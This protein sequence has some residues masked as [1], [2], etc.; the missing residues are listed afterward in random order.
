M[1]ETDEMQN[2]LLDSA[3]HF[4]DG[5]SSQDALQMPGSSTGAF[6]DNGD[7]G[8][9]DSGS[10]LLKPSRKKVNALRSARLCGR[11]SKST[12]ASKTQGGSMKFEGR[13]KLPMPKID[14]KALFDYHFR[15]KQHRN[16][17]RW[18]LSVKA[19]KRRSPEP[20]IKRSWPR[21][22]KDERERRCRERGRQFPFVEKLYG[23]KH[24]PL[25]MVC[26]YEQAALKGYFKY[27]EM[28]K[29]EHHLKKSLARLNAEDDLEHKGLESRK[30]KYLDDDGSL[31]P[32]E[33]TNGDDQNESSGDEEIGAKIVENSCF[34]L[35]S[36]IPKKK[37]CKRK[38]K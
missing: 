13:L 20:C 35:S 21:V 36:T 15:R 30:Y 6:S 8:M 10:Q 19:T 17:K 26:L 12:S 32:I 33:E 18:R 38:S 28:L 22:S 37:T 24:I 14:L 29:Y 7:S 34:I 1:A 4:T 27:I 3:E 11:S 31:S 16:R 2:S 25:K 23:R 5:H 9:T